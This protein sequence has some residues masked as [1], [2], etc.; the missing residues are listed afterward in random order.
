MKT[1]NKCGVQKPLSQFYIIKDSDRNKSRLMAS[2]KP[3][4]NTRTRNNYTIEKSTKKGHAYQIYNKRK[5]YAK[6]NNIPFDIDFEYIFS[7]AENNCPILN[8]TL[9]WGEKTKYP[10]DN[11]PSLDKIIPEL[12]YIKN[13]VR[14]ISYRANTIKSNGTLEEHMAI[15]KYIKSA[16]K[17]L[18]K[19]QKN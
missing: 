13:N 9:N 17:Y 2:C 3:C 12:G 1:C 8:M 4:A 19:H 18:K 5:R 16:I 7:L 10:Q 6:R 11:S 14:W 15:A